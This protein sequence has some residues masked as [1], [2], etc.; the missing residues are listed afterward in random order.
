MV[1][2]IDPQNKSSTQGTVTPLS[3]FM[4]WMILER[5]S[6]VVLVMNKNFWET[7]FTFVVLIMNNSCGF[8]S[9]IKDDVF[10]FC[11]LSGKFVI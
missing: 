1:T 11:A 10:I 8:L 6:T 7:S 5:V 2:H 9:F 3:L 4:A